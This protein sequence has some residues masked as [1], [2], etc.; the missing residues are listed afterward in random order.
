MYENQMIIAVKNGEGNII[1]EQSYHE[2]LN[3]K[4]NIEIL[5]YYT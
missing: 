3:G 4:K 1:A 2:F 5:N